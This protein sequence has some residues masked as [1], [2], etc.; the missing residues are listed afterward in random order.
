MENCFWDTGHLWSEKVFWEDVL[1]YAG[2]DVKRNPLRVTIARLHEAYYFCCALTMSIYWPVIA[3]AC[4]NVWS[5]IIGF[6]P[7][8]YCH[9]LTNSLFV[10]DTNTSYVIAY[11]TEN[12]RTKAHQCLKVTRATS[13]TKNLASCIVLAENT[14]QQFLNFFWLSSYSE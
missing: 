1:L 2:L 4:G 3:Y 12:I 14:R 11:A 6:Y 7:V 9:S 13:F 10:C 5:Q 8:L